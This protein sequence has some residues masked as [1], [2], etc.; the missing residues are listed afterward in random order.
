MVCTFVHVVQTIQ[1]R[2]R[3]DRASHP[4]WLQLWRPQAERAMRTL[5]VVVPHE[6]A[7]HGPEMLLMQ[8]DQVVEALAAKV[9]ITRSATVFARG[10]GIG[11]AMASIPIRRVCSRRSRP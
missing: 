9:P 6:L 2:A 5:S 1:D 7:Q 8:D 11:V 4:A 3:P 10:D